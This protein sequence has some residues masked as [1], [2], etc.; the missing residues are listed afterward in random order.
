MLDQETV[1]EYIK[2]QNR[3]SIKS[4]VEIIGLDLLF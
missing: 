1:Y 2:E 3:I 4:N